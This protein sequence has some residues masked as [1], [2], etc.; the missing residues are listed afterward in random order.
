MACREQS[1]NTEFRYGFSRHV[2]RHQYRPSSLGSQYDA[3][4]QFTSNDFPLKVIPSNR[5]LICEGV[6][7]TLDVGLR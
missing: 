2:L 1:R 5:L 7:T 4:S 3:R 6:L